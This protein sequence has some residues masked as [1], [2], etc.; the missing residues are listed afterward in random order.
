MNVAEPKKEEKN[1]T[2]G[3]WYI[4]NLRGPLKAVIEAVE[5]API[6]NHWKEAIKADI[7]A[8]TQKT[9]AANFFFVDAHYFIANGKA[10]VH[11]T[12]EPDIVLS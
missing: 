3:W 12:I 2:E 1:P 10:D 7:Q 8:I 6:P 4:A 9:P 5:A 11:I